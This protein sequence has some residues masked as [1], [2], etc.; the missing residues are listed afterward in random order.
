MNIQ[1]ITKKAFR[2]LSSLIDQTIFKIGP[3]HRI[4][5]LLTANEFILI[6]EEKTKQYD[7][8][9]LIS[10]AIDRKEDPKNI[11]SLKI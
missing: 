4:E 5:F 3:V 6:K 11:F 7:K 8:Y 10:I 9:H 2:K 1:N